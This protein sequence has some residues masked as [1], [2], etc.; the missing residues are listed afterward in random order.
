[1]GNQ[2]SMSIWK[3]LLVPVVL[4]IIF[5]L[6]IW[7]I[8]RLQKNFQEQPT[9]DVSLPDI[10]TS[11]EEN[12]NITGKVTSKAELMVNNKKIL[13]DKDGNFSYLL[14]LNQ[15]E[16]KVVFKAKQ[17]Q[18]DPVI[19]EKIINRE[20]KAVKAPAAG[21]PSETVKAESLAASGPAE[22]MGIVGLAGLLLSYLIYRKTAKGRFNL[23]SRKLFTQ[24]TS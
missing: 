19:V 3:Q 24:K 11:T 13:V 18:S 6:A 17:G 23:V 14:A 21:A 9:L 7:G 22:N 15:G 5:S 10:S 12:I 1:M 20:A 8:V 2:T 16:N 4:L